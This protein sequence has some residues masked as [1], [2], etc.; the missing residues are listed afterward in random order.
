M[1]LKNKYVLAQ[2]VQD[3]MVVMGYSGSFD[4]SYDTIS[5]DGSIALFS[6]HPVVMDSAIEADKLRREASKQILEY[7]KSLTSNAGCFDIGLNEAY[8]LNF[9]IMTLKEL[10]GMLEVSFNEMKERSINVGLHENWEGIIVD[11]K[12]IQKDKEANNG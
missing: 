9:Q 3:F 4:P 8:Y 12:A 6:H 10:C 1:K 5:L 7:E 11:K 2:K